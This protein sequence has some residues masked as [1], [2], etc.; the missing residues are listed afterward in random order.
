MH[1]FENITKKLA[2]RNYREIS[3][4]AAV[5]IVGLTYS[6]LISLK[7]LIFFT[8]I[9]FSVLIANQYRLY[10]IKKM[11]LTEKERQLF[12]DKES[13]LL[14]KAW[15][16]YVLPITGPFIIDI[17]F[18]KNEIINIF[19]LSIFII[20]SIFIARLNFYAATKLQ[21]DYS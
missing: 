3:A 5:I 18:F 10:K 17:L 6:D 9:P 16:W 15:A 19:S 21:T 12:I 13:K 1:S 7:P 4:I 8:L 11:V 14:K 20:I 2:W